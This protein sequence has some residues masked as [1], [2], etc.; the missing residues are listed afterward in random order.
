MSE[1]GVRR[2]K[3]VLSSRYKS[4]P[5]NVPAGSNRSSY[6]PVRTQPEAMV[7]LM[8]L[9]GLIGTAQLEVEAEHTAPFVGSGRIAVLEHIIGLAANFGEVM[10]RVQP[11]CQF[12]QPLEC[13]TVAWTAGS[14]RPTLRPVGKLPAKEPA[15]EGEG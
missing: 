10:R 11:K 1:S 13:P 15:V 7:D 12:T 9:T 8:P 4:H 5:A 6:E 14:K 3:A 2:D